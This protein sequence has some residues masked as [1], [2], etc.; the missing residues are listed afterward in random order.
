[1]QTETLKV[2]GMTCGGCA[3]KVSNAL[4]AVLGVSDAKVTFSAGVAEVQ[5]D[6]KV[7]SPG[8]LNT[9]LMNAGYVVDAAK[10]D[11]SAGSCCG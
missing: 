5:Y 10:P 11:Q 4:Q 9:A 8:Q 7:T 2:I 1:M 3:K 6:E